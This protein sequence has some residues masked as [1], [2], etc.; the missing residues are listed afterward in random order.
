MSK[1]TIEPSHSNSHSIQRLD[2][3]IIV[4]WL[5][6]KDMNYDASGKGFKSN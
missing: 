2:S 3:R 6:C 1:E 5:V 4:Q